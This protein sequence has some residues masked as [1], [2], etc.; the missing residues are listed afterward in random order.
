LAFPIQT[1]RQDA[2]T[3]SG[4]DILLAGIYGM[5]VAETVNRLNEKMREAT[6]APPPSPD[7]ALVETTTSVPDETV[8]CP[9]CGEQVPANFS[10]CWKCGHILKDLRPAG[11]SDA[12]ESD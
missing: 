6:G 4:Y 1:C 10:E 8:V 2:D 7:P 11:L 12:S 3:Y 9:K 5:S